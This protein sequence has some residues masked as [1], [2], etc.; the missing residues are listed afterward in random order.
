MLEVE[1]LAHR[2]GMLYKGRLIGEGSPREL[3]SK[4][5]ASNLEE[6]FVKLKSTSGG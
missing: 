1:Y 5:S 3:K 4:L 2:V 6:V